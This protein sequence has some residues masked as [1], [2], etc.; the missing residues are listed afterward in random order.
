MD[1]RL[2]SNGQEETEGWVG[3]EVRFIRRVGYWRSQ[4]TSVRQMTYR[5]AN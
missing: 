3:K 2:L 5:P 1:A 4:L